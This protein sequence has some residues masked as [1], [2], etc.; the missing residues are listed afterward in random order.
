[1]IGSNSGPYTVGPKS[2]MSMRGHDGG[3]IL[4]FLFNALQ[5]V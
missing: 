4:P 3:G 1:M 2:V 5:W